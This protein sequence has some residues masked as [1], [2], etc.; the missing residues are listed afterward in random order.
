MPQLNEKIHCYQFNYEP[1]V[2]YLPRIRPYIKTIFKVYPPCIAQLLHHFLEVLV[3]PRVTCLL[4]GGPCFS[5]EVSAASRGSLPLPGVLYLFQGVFSSSRGSLSL[6]R[7]LCL[8]QGVP[9]SSRG[10]LPL[11]AVLC[12][13]Q[14]IL[15][16]SRGYCHF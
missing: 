5:Q 1:T 12:L 9:A 6:S 13:F 8:F 2:I 15:A 10:S 7:G 11:P 16:P 4:P 14:G 3:N